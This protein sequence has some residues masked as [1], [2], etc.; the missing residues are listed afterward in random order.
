M[1][2]Q[3]SADKTDILLSIT[4]TLVPMIVGAISATFIGPFIDQAQLRDLLAGL[5]AALYYTAVR[6]IETKFP[7]AGIFLGSRA[8]PTY[9]L[10]E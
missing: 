2:T 8:K 6:F 1:T 9:E 3:K 10:P 7:A 5:I 4:R